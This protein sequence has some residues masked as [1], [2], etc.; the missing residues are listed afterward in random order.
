MFRFLLAAGLLLPQV[1]F[2]QLV[3]GAFQEGSYVLAESRM[4]RYQGQLRLQ[5]GATLVVKNP[6]GKN[7]K[8]TPAEVASFRIGSQRYVPAGNFH[9]IVGLGGL[10]IE[11]VF[12]EPLDS[13]QVQ[14]LRCTY[15]ANMPMATSVAGAPV[16]GGSWNLSTYLLRTATDARYTAVQSGAYSNGGKR[17]RDAL[18]PFLATR[19]DLL[20]MLDKKRIDAKN[21]PAVIHALNTN[22]PYSPLIEPATPTRPA[23][24]R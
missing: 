12:A 22:Q 3:G 5:D 1:G 15:A 21:L 9:V 2:A 17:F 16:G 18:K 14:L 10:D 13:G 20:H 6:D 7:L 11:A 23:D 8:L 19:P 4:I 24:S